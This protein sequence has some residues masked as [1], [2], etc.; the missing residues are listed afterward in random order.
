MSGMEARMHK[1]FDGARAYLTQ[2][3]SLPLPSGASDSEERTFMNSIEQIKK[4]LQG[5]NLEEGSENAIPPFE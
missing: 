2:F 3:I 5:E 4:F 1:K